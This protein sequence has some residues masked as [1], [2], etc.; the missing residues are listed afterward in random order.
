MPN[1]LVT[2]AQFSAFLQQNSA[3]AVYFGSPDCAVCAALK[4]RVLACLAAEFPRIAVGLVDC[5][6][7]PELAAQQAVWAVPTLTVYFD[8]QESLRL[9]RNFSPAQLAGQLERPY[10][11]YFA[12]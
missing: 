1:T 5:V 8:G 9:S 3:A 6:A 4:P 10:A 7:A 2:I 12:A 11:T